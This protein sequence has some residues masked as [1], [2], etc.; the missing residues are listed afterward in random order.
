M[1]DTRW[2]QLPGFNCTF[3]HDFFHI[4]AN[5]LKYVCLIVQVQGSSLSR[6]LKTWQCIVKLQCIIRELLNYVGRSEKADYDK[7]IM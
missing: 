1:H 3:L 6:A 2:I 7:V 5:Y 4:N